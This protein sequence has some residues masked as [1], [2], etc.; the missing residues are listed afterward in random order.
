MQQTITAIGMGWGSDDSSGGHGHGWS[1]LALEALALTEYKEVVVLDQKARV[2]VRARGYLTWL[3][4]VCGGAVRI[5][6]FPCSGSRS[7]LGS[8][9]IGLASFLARFGFAA[10]RSI[11]FCDSAL[12]QACCARVSCLPLLFFFHHKSSLLSWG[13][14]GTEVAQPGDEPPP[15]RIAPC[16]LL[17][18][19]WSRPANTPTRKQAPRQFPRVFLPARV[20]PP[21]ASSR[22]GGVKRLVLPFSTAGAKYC[23]KRTRCLASSV[24]GCCRLS[25]QVVI[26]SPPLDPTQTPRQL[27][28]SS[29]NRRRATAAATVDP[30]RAGRQAEQQ[31]R[32]EGGGGAEQE[33]SRRR[34]LGG[35]GGSGGGGADGEGVGPGE[36]RRTTAAA[37]AGTA[38][39]ADGPRLP[40]LVPHGGDWA[41]AFAEGAESSLAQGVSFPLLVCGG[42]RG[43]S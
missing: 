13:G 11:Q 26:F 21:F 4:G 34:L 5:G 8:R 27:H 30:E 3:F 22:N 33:E 31:G 16:P 6:L 37:G 29:G 17:P 35:E 36:M 23:C 2:Y 9:K 40:P 25:L 10:C 42:V 32:D 20:H 19:F 18:G 12:V 15:H 1:L 39:G 28:S 43:A 24:P 14:R 41:V 38:A 7:R